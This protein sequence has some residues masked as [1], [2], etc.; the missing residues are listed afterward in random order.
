MENQRPNLYTLPHIRILIFL[1]H[2]R[3]MRHPP[4]PPVDLTIKTLDQQHL[5]RRLPMQIPPFVSLIRP[6]RQ[7]LSPSIRID[8]PPRDQV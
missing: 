4:R 8:Q 2:K 5:L 7:R 6:H 3:R 1:I